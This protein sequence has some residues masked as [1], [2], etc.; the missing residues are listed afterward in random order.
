MSDESG[1]LEFVGAAMDVTAAKETEQ[2]LKCSEAYLHEAQRLAH[3]G[4]SVRNASSGDFIAS[5]EFQRI[6][7]FDPD[8]EKPT[9]EMFRDRIHPDD[10]SRRCRD[11]Q[12]GQ[13]RKTRYEADF[14]ICSSRRIDKALPQ[15]CYPVFDGSGEVAEY[16]TT[17]LE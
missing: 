3:M 7:G 6:F 14:R 16:F 15:R 11:R 8:K 5:P 17:I 9:F 12:Q 1:D 2:R 10:H 13:E 4:S